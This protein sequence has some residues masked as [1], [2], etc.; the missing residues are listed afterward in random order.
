MVASVHTYASPTGDASNAI[1]NAEIFVTNL[2]GIGPWAQANGIMVHVSEFG[3]SSTNSIAMQTC[4]NMNAYMNSLPN[5]F[6][7][8]SWW[9]DGLPSWYGSYIFTMCPSNNYTTPSA[10]QPLLQQFFTTK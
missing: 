6:I 9:C 4:A 2:E 10:N 1:T 8:C 3:C 7:G 5:V